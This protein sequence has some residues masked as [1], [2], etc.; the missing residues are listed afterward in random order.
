MHSFADCANAYYNDLAENQL[1]R[2]AFIELIV[3]STGVFGDAVVTEFLGDPSG[4]NL[5]SI[6]NCHV[7]LYNLMFAWLSWTDKHWPDLCDL[8]EYDRLTRPVVYGD[9]F[10]WSIVPEVAEHFG[11]PQV[12][13]EVAKIGMAMTPEDKGD[14]I[15][16]F[17]QI[18]NS[19]FLKQ[20]PVLVDGLYYP[21]KAKTEIEEMTNWCTNAANL[22]EM[23][24]DKCT[25]MMKLAAF[26]GAEYYNNLRDVTQ[27]CLN[28]RGCTSV[29]PDFAFQKDCH[30]RAW[31][32]ETA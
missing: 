29:L 9:D 31:F 6:I 5:T 22:L 8:S 15:L 28:I 3:N 30:R 24:F 4:C 23:T 16:Q 32:G 17:K 2:K 19:T 11:L 27:E 1:A 12:I 26:H 20:K 21:Q 18:E 25:D 10:W 13:A 7:N 14:I